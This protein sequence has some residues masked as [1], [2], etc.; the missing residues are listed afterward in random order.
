MPPPGH[1]DDRQRVREASDIVDVIGEVCQLKPK[2]R[3]FVCLCPFHDDRNPSM[4]VVPG[5]QIFHCFVCGAGGDVFTFV[6]KYHGL[7]FREVLEML[8]ERAGIELARRAPREQGPAGDTAEPSRTDL[9][10][11]NAFAQA[12][13]RRL[14]ERAD[15]GTAA[16]AVLVERGITPEMQDRFG[17]G[18]AHPE[19]WDGLLQT[20]GAKAAAGVTPDVLVQAGL[21]K[22][23]PDGSAYDAFRHRLT[24]PICDQG[25]RAIAFGGRKINPDDEPKYLNSAESMVFDKSRTL[26]GLHLAT[27]GIKRENRAVVVEGYTDVIAC[28]QAGIDSAVATLGTSL[29]AG[30]A[31]VLRRLC[32]TVVLLFDG[33]EAGQRAADRAVSVFLAENLDVRIATL[34]GATD[35]K[36]PDELLKLDGGV[37]VLLGVLDD[38]VD[39][40]RFKFSRVAARVRRAGPAERL[41]IVQE[42]LRLFADAGFSKVPPMRQSMIIGQLAGLLGVTESDVRRAMPAGRRPLA[43]EAGETAA[44]IELRP[45]SRLGPGDAAVGCLLTRPALSASAADISGELGLEENHAD[46]PFAELGRRVA[47]LLQNGRDVTYDA[48][49]SEHGDSTDLAPSLARLLHRIEAECAGG[50]DRVEQMFNDAVRELRRRSEERSSAGGDNDDPLERLRRRRDLESKYGGSMTSSPFRRR[51]PAGA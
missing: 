4:Y 50:H 31:R 9:F 34:A 29:T 30:H 5:K 12:Y 2:G 27:P 40:L 11:A 17:L 1:T 15:T 16:R 13:F 33:D 48:A 3:E 7:G 8:A 14:L 46:P 6:E 41:R 47:S 24:F 10:R 18:C 49:L 51:R 20:V 39:L 38:A 32:D 23:R 21:A 36:D 42:E 37:A 22:P 44:E 35:A 45:G 19:L 43:T 28:H 26:Y 25:G